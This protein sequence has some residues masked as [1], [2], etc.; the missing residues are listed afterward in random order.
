MLD[1]MSEG[2]SGNGISIRPDHKK[3]TDEEQ[4]AEEECVGDNGYDEIGG[5]F[6]YE[7]YG[8]GVSSG[9]CAQSSARYHQQT[10]LYADYGNDNDNDSSDESKS[11][12]G[13]E[14][15]LDDATD[16]ELGDNDDAMTMTMSCTA[17][18]SAA[19]TACR[20]GFLQ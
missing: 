6:E 13:K 3:I 19:A 17:E 20:I 4:D 14:D 1:D 8:G 18:V 12:N 5:D 11:N 15:D 16:D 10:K 9:S 7:L 2:G